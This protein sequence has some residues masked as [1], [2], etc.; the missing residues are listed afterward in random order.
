MCASVV[1]ALSF[2]NNNLCNLWLS[3]PYS[4]VSRMIDFIMG[5]AAQVM[6]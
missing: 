4:A 1:T 3:S 6:V 5:A 2:P